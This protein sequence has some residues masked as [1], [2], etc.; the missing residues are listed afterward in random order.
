MPAKKDADIIKF[1]WFTNGVEKAIIAFWIIVIVGS[2]TYFLTRDTFGTFG[3]VLMEAGVL[4]LS[5]SLV[6][7]LFFNSYASYVKFIGSKKF[8]VNG[9][10]NL[11]NNLSGSFWSGESF[12]SVGFSIE[13]AKEEGMKIRKAITDFLSEFVKVGNRKFN[14]NFSISLWTVKGQIRLGKSSDFFLRE[15]MYK[16]GTLHDQFP[17]SN[18]SLTINV[19]GET[20]INSTVGDSTDETWIEARSRYLDEKQWHDNDLGGS[21]PHHH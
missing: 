9:G 4:I 7:L 19:A 15:L 3:I 21:H 12:A 11:F 10:N 2:G 20:N 17:G 18:F 6:A 8:E 16:L 1:F 14:G 13:V 5:V